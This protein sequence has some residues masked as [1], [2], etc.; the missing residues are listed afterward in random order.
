MNKWAICVLLL[1][2]AS[3]AGPDASTDSGDGSFAA[4]D[5]ADGATPADVP[6]NT[7]VERAKHNPLTSD[8]RRGATLKIN[9]LVDATGESRN[10]LL[11]E[12]IEL[13]PR[14]LPFFRSVQNE[15]VVLDMVYVIRRIEEMHGIEPELDLGPDVSV[16]DP[17]EGSS[18]SAE[19]SP[20]N[21]NDNLPETPDY[22]PTLED[23]NYDRDEIEKFLGTRLAQ[24]RQM[25]AAGSFEA[26]ESVAEAAIVLVP[27]SKLR[28]DFE[29]IITRARNGIQA[30]MLVAGTI[31]FSP[32]NLQYSTREKGSL[33]KENLKINLFLKNV[34][35]SDLTLKM[36]SGNDQRSVVELALDYR[37]TDYAGNDMTL[38]GSKLLPVDAEG[39][40]TLKPDE[41]YTVEV[42][43]DGLSSLDA[44]APQKY[45]LGRLTLNA[46][47]RLHGAAGPDGKPVT[48]RPVRFTKKVA[49]VFP[50]GFELEK[51]QKS[52][53]TMISKAITDGSAQNLF[54]ASQ[55]VGKDDIRRASDVL[56]AEDLAESGVRMRSVRIKALSGIHGRGSNWG[57]ERWVK[58][59]RENRFNY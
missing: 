29:E 55:L 39:I 40:V 19:P 10:M 44:T 25:L 4:A 27:E 14:F 3:C 36:S 7:F 23:L 54:L 33:F 51:A 49:N 41:S 1:V 45:V 21:G 2:V 6:P 11:R 34:S 32:D 31:R 42:E 15:S 16:D 12:L 58:W 48:L 28:P 24:A 18:S 59:W 26:A 46:T 53:G 38:S 5:Y 8:E 47:L 37:Q 56:A 22:N 50:A 17:G 35:G 57:P 13:G 52:P 43:L 30:E 9:G 20:E